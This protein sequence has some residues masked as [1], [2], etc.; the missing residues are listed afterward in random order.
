MIGAAVPPAALHLGPRA[1]ELLVCAVSER[2]GDPGG[3]VLAGDLAAVL[4]VEQ[5]RRRQPAGGLGQPLVREALG[6]AKCADARRDRVVGHGERS[7]TR[8]RGHTLQTIAFSHGMPIAVVIRYFVPSVPREMSGRREG[9]AGRTVGAA[10]GRRGAC[11]A[12]SIAWPCPPG[13]AGAVAHDGPIHGSGLLATAPVPHTPGLP[14][15]GERRGRPSGDR[16]P[17]TRATAVHPRAAPTFRV[18]TLAP[19]RHAARRPLGPPDI[20]RGAPSGGPSGPKGARRYRRVRRPT[21]AA[22]RVW[23][24]RIGWGFTTRPFQEASC[25]DA[26]A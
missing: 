25:C 19:P 4:D 22:C 8:E 12:E 3:Y 24:A 6:H 11:G 26:L 15:A 13:R 5:E 2:D 9:V 1:I 16:R 10:R 21:G 23:A 17:P 20:P 14:R 18:A 7:R